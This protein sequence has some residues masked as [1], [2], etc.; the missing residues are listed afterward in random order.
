MSDDVEGLVGPIERGRVVDGELV[1]VC[2]N[3]PGLSGFHSYHEGELVSPD[4]N[5]V[6]EGRLYCC[7]ECLR[8]LDQDTGVVVERPLRVVWTDEEFLMGSP[9]V[10]LTR[11]E[12]Q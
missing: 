2:G 3:H 6:W 7:L 1:C 12:G 10:W 11:T 9:P 5:G 4:V 8:V